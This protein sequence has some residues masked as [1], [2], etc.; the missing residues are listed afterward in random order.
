M[1]ENQGGKRS[2]TVNGGMVNRD[3]TVREHN[4][5]GLKSQLIFLKRGKNMDHL[6]KD[7]GI[8]KFGYNEYYP[9]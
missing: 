5:L 9:R 7:N 2:G 3:L 6:T 1:K 4:P 8:F